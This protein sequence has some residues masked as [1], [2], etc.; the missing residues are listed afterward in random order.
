MTTLNILF[1][2]ASAGTSG[3]GSPNRGGCDWNFAAAKNSIPAATISLDNGST[4][5]SGSGTIRLGTGTNVWNVGAMNLS[6]GRLNGTLTYFNATD[7]GCRLRG[8]GGLHSSRVN[9]MALGNRTTGASAPGSS[10]RPRSL[11]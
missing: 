5:S 8:V 6:A 11:N 10:P 9:T 7:G 3:A 2:G 4:S 1:Y